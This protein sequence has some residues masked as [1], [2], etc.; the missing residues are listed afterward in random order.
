MRV[1]KDSDCLYRK[2]SEITAIC[3]SRKMICEGCENV[4]ACEYSEKHGKRN[5]YKIRNI[6]YAV[7][8]IY[9]NIGTKGLERYFEPGEKLKSS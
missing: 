6:K 4:L 7:L 5:K 3:Y 1:H 9:A 2:W 8:R